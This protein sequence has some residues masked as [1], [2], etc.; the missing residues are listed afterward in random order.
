M[1]HSTSLCYAFDTFRFDVDQ[2]VLTRAG[3]AVS[4]TPKA[5]D[6]LI[7]LLRNAGQLV[8]KDELMKEVWPNT[9]VEEAN[10]T[11]NIFT[12]RRALGETE[13]GR[14]YIETVARRGYRFI[15]DVK[16]AK[17]PAR[18]CRDLSSLDD[19]SLLFVVVGRDI[20]FRRGMLLR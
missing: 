3:K 9:F 16:F 13:S 7:L 5:T 18:G 19:D 10:V 20:F 2:R 14:R 8:E 6:I 4:L 12:L 17:A 15:A 1:P 11:Q